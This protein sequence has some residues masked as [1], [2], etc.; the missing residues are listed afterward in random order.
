M[1]YIRVLPLNIPNAVKSTEAFK[2]LHFIVKPMA[3]RV[4]HITFFPDEVKALHNQKY[5]FPNS[6]G[7]YCNVSLDVLVK[8]YF[9]HM[10][11]VEN[12]RFFS[13]S[14]KVD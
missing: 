6:A 13:T 4:A 8:L 9:L 7:F 5:K 10:H 3:S 14:R 1:M 12:F 11:A 2:L